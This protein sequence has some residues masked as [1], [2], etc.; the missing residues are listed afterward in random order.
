MREAGPKFRD[1]T[2]TYLFEGSERTAIFPARSLRWAALLGPLQLQKGS[3]IIKIEE[4]ACA[5]S[6]ALFI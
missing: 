6:T 3:E 1:F 2:I 5:T 4:S